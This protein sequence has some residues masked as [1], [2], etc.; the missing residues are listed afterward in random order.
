MRKSSAPP[1]GAPRVLQCGGMLLPRRQFLALSG[2][3]GLRAQLAD[4]TDDK[5]RLPLG[6]SLYA[7]QDFRIGDAVE[8][9][10][11]LGYEAVEIALNEG[12]PTEPA[13]LTRG[14]RAQ[15][16]FQLRD[17]DIRLPAMMERLLLTAD[18]AGHARNLEK[19]RL[20]AQLG[21]DVV[22]DAPPL[23]ETV[24]GGTPAQW[25]ELKEPMAAR[26]AD[27]AKVAGEVDQTIAIKAHVSGAAHLPE[28]ILWLLGQ[29]RSRHIRAVYDFS[30]FHLR[31][32]DLRGSLRDLLPETVFVHVKDAR[33]TPEKPE[34]LLPGAGGADYVQLLQLLHE[35][36]YRGPVVVEVSAQ[37]QRQP[38]YS[39]LDA[40][41][42]AY[43]ALWAAYE[44]AGLR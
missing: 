15:L 2:A 4:L 28:H 6:F 42:E 27:W 26:L 41:D 5:L 24:L 31:G 20:A 25:E 40:A 34:F 9:C 1:T 10:A 11:R 30:H 38:G 37:L 18:D 17:L 35:G 44:E 7:M 21:H 23:L 29:V 14:D 22:P 16:S 32:L 12:W 3:T 8:Y 19:I 36:G 13:K 43:E 33:G 39:A